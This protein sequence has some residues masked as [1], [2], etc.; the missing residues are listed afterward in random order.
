[1][2]G[3]EATRQAQKEGEEA[4]AAY[5]QEKRDIAAGKI[6]EPPP[7]PEKKKPVKKDPKEKGGPT[8]KPSKAPVSSDSTDAKREKDEV[9]PGKLKRKG[10]QRDSV[11][12]EKKPRMM[13]MQA[14]MEREAMS[15][16]VSKGATKAPVLGQRENLESVSD[17]SL[18]ALVSK[19]IQAAKKSILWPTFLYPTAAIEPLRSCL[20][21]QSTAEVTP[22]G[23]AML[24]G[25]PADI[26]WS[27]PKFITDNGI[28]EDVSL[29]QM[30]AVEYDDEGMNEKFRSVM[31]G[32]VCVIGQA[33]KRMLRQFQEIGGG[34]LGLGCGVGPLDCHI[35]GV[36]G[37]CSP[38]AAC[39]LYDGEVFR[40]SCLSDTD[41]VTLN[42]ERLSKSGGDGS[43]LYDNDVCSVGPRVF[44]FVLPTYK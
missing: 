17:D 40:F 19:R 26:G 16:V 39:I 12:G 29:V 15:A 24:V 6:P 18:R 43:V 20:P 9:G 27:F 32:S 22:V 37:T 5:E 28:Q 34:N 42:G 35:G 25:L 8:K 30:L 33:S 38:F 14:K 41:V 44:A 21:T 23:S 10:S 13:D 31:Q 11:T 4:A 36:P 1:M 3:E 7:K 2:Y